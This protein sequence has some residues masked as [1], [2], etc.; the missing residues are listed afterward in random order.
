MEVTYKGQTNYQINFIC[1]PL[2]IE[3]AIIFKIY[4]FQYILI[5]LL[6]KQNLH[7]AISNTWVKPRTMLLMSFY[8]KNL[9]LALKVKDQ[10]IPFNQGG[11]IAFPQRLFTLNINLDVIFINKC[12]S[13]I[14]TIVHLVNFLSCL[15]QNNNC[16][17]SSL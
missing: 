10:A 6:L 2:L 9:I 7:Y 16:G 3:T 11:V 1:Y 12:W 5:I 13:F 8:W 17:K 14:I 15:K 4:K